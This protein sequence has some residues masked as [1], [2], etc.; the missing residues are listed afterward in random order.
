MSKENQ[1]N[2]V[3]QR[4]TE[5]RRRGF[6]R[7]EEELALKQRL[8]TP[9]LYPAETHDP[10]VTDRLAEVIRLQNGQAFSLESY[11]AENLVEY[12]SR[13]PK[14]YYRL[15][16]KLHGL[17]SSVM[18]PYKKPECAAEFTIVFIYGRFSILV[19]RELRR[20][21]PWTEIPGVRANKLFQ[22]LTTI[23][24]EMLDLY[25]EQALELMRET[26]TFQEFKLAFS[27]KFG[28]RVQRDMFEDRNLK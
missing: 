23:A 8:L 13:F 5:T 26:N 15:I 27:K 19:L 22:Y 24:S 18:D 21:S 25:I 7:T 1:E 4:P 16:A 20:K 2:Q 28:I 10:V 3:Q 11:I 6:S 14:E 9:E 12:K 17:D